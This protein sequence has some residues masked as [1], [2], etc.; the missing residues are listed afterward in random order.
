V[1]T[2]TATLGLLPT[3]TSVAVPPPDTAGDVRQLAGPSVRSPVTRERI[4]SLMTD[5]FANGD[6]SNDDQPSD[7]AVNEF[8]PTHK[9]FYH[10]GDLK[11]L[12]AK[13]DYIKASARRRTGSL[14]RCTTTGCSA[15]SRRSRRPITATG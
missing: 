15:R 2:L 7:E 1:G 13:L 12:T 8:D 3:A 6:Q 4:Y 14:R 5:R 10:G 11:G 9:G